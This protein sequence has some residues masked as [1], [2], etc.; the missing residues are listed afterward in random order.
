MTR[1][2]TGNLSRTILVRAEELGTKLRQRG[3]H[4]GTAES[5]TGGLVSA[6]FTDVSGASDWFW[7]TI[8]SYANEVKMGV[9][10]VSEQTMIDHGAVS[11]PVVM[12]MA[13]GA[14]KTLGVDLAVS[15]SGI[16]GPTG[17]TADKPVGTVW[18]GT[19]SPDGTVAKCFHFDGDRTSVR[20]Q[21]VLAAIDM[22]HSCLK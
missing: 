9:L 11:E 16:A 8:V 10:G 21:S 19:H 3:W 1:I 18:I 17:G 15:L 13:E 22:L 7:G 14:C 4:V 2:M 12:Q 6:A 5:C 20:Q